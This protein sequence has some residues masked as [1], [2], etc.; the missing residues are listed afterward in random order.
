LRDGLRTP[1]PVGARIWQNSIR[2]Q[3][4]FIQRLLDG[5]QIERLLERFPR[6]FAGKL[7]G[8]G[9]PITSTSDRRFEFV[10]EAKLT[11]RSLAL[12]AVLVA[13]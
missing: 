6:L 12:A 9:T 7:V 2:C 3:Q 5:A 4:R 8:P 10:A 13:A 1:R 11:A